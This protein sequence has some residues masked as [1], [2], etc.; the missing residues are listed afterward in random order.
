MSSSRSRKTKL[1]VPQK[2]SFLIPLKYVDVVRRTR[3]ALDVLQECMI[4]DHWSVEGDRI[5]SGQWTDFA[6]APLR[7]LTLSGGRLTKI[8]ANS[9]SENTRPEVWSGMSNQCQQKEKTA[10]GRGKAEARQCTKAERYLS[11]QSGR[12]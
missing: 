11:D 4:D 1:Y 12:Q 10:L 7:G 3:I 9:R 5:P 8:Q 6:H 2:S